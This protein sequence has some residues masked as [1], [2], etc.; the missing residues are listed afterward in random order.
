MLLAG[1]RL[2]PNLSRDTVK[3]LKARLERAG[4]KEGWNFDTP[5]R[6]GTRRPKITRGC[7]RSY[8]SSL[9]RILGN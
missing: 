9:T 5:S 4:V 6:S 3:W 8:N 2:T 1:R 7:D